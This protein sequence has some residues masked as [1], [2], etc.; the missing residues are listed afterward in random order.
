MARAELVD[1]VLRVSTGRTVG[2]LARGPED[3]RAVVHLH[4][5]PGSRLE[6]HLVFPDDVLERF[7]IRAVSVDRPGYGNT[8]PLPGGRLERAQ[9]VLAVAD[10]LGIDRFALVGV[11]S[12]GTNALTLAAVA[13]G[14]VDRVVLLSAQMP[15]DDDEAIVALQAGQAFG[16]PYLRGGRS[17][18]IEQ[19]YADVRAAT[20]ADPVGG[21]EELTR[22]LSKR[23]QMWYS[24]A[25][26]RDA[27]VADMQEALRVGAEGYI[28][29]GLTCV[30]PFEVDVSAVMCPVR[31]VHGTADDWEPLANLRRFLDQLPDAQLFLLDG[32]N[33]FGGIMYPDFA[34]SLCL[35]P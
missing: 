2:F 34:A 16:L 14:R 28:E 23:E 3:G 30:R 17:E 20:L 4:G 27:F 11:S 13:S 24:Q 35:S 22:T 25:W 32:M 21:F 31:A 12:G 26:V 9:D 10:A 33:H 6:Q 19:Y 7:G 1:D 29:D 8:D 5:A 18:L 15:Y